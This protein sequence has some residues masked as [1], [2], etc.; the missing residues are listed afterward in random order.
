MGTTRGFGILA[1]A[2][3][4]VAAI[5][6]AV[7]D[8]TVRGSCADDACATGIP[9]VAVTFAALAVLAL[10]VSAIPAVQWIVEHTRP[11]K[12]TDLEVERELERLAR[13]RETR[14]TSFDDV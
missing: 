5:S 13:S 3:I 2:A 10:L 12:D 11:V 1:V 8:V 7:V 9:A 4:A 6:F 14:S